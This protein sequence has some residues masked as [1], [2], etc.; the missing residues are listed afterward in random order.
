LCTIVLQVS[1]SSQVHW[2]EQ[3]SGRSVIGLLRNLRCEVLLVGLRLE[4]Y[5]AWAM[6][7][8]CGLCHRLICLLLSSAIVDGVI[9]YEPIVISLVFQV[10]LIIL[11]NIINVLASDYIVVAANGRE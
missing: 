10:L 7:L 3:A 1:S 2:V 8:I 9:I 5:Q 6:P 11:I 4:L